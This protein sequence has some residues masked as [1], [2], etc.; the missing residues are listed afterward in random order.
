MAGSFTHAKPTV[1]LKG[2]IK[3]LFHAALG[4]EQKSDD[5]LFEI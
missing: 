3:F 4:R 2:V 1:E 5:E